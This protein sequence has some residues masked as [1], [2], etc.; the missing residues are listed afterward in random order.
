MEI[1]QF[2]KYYT[3]GQEKY[4][5]RLNF[6]YN[7]R[8]FELNDLLRELI[9]Q[10]QLDTSN[11]TYT[12]ASGTAQIDTGIDENEVEGSNENI[13]HADGTELLI[14]QPE[15]V[16]AKYFD[17]NSL[18]SGNKGLIWKQ[19]YRLTRL[20]HEKDNS[21]EHELEEV[22]RDI[23]EIKELFEVFCGFCIGIFDFDRMEYEEILDT[24][25]PRL[26]SATNTQMLIMNR[27][28]LTC[29]CHNDNLFRESWDKMG[30]SPYLIIPNS[31]IAHNSFL[32]ENTEAYI[33]DIIN[34]NNKN[35]TYKALIKDKKMIDEN[36]N[37]K[38]L[39]NVFQYPTEQDLYQ[40]GHQ[41]RGINELIESIKEK[42]VEL[43]DNINILSERRR[44]VF[45]AI[46]GL[47]LGIVSLA[48]I[49]DPLKEA[50]GA[51]ANVIWFSIT[52]IFS[53]G[54]IY[55]IRKYYTK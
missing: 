39:S 4:I 50:T 13:I 43:K 20:S 51:F 32:I 45:E 36:L 22:M 10:T 12:I 48:Q 38:L 34:L 9:S 5:S 1:I 25:N 14:K 7:D 47:L 40:F 31:V 35:K 53:I 37:T 41:H 16:L 2:I 15:D 6:K 28:A 18:N 33:D 17:L 52:I 24:I 49:Y 11:K 46:I 54:Y 3:G 23:P 42:K 8:N 26:E 55:G 19:I 21:N 27:N 44:K 29:F 30:I